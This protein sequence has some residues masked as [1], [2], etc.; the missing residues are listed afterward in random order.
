M[1]TFEMQGAMD[2][3]YRPQTPLSAADCDCDS[4]LSPVDRSVAA[5]VRGP[6][7]SPGTEQLTVRWH[8]YWLVNDVRVYGVNKWAPPTP[9]PHAPSGPTKPSDA[10]EIGEGTIIAL[11]VIGGLIGLCCAYKAWES[12]QMHQYDALGRKAE[13]IAALNQCAAHSPH[14]AC[15]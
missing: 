7:T 3:S 6:H 11:A 13:R 5:S 15:Q 8:R 10:D 12:C 2:E 4:R 14:L 1:F 9:G